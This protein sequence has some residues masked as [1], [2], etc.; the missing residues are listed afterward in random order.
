M[1]S[2]RAAGDA[3]AVRGVAE[4][5]LQGVVHHVARAGRPLGDV[6]FVQK[7]QG[8]AVHLK[9]VEVESGQIEFA[10]T[11][12]QE[13][14]DIL[15]GPRPRIWTESAGQLL[16]DVEEGRGGWLSGRGGGETGKRIAPQQIRTER[17]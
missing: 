3:A 14:D 12:S 7:A 17:K 1:R 10:F 9:F 5:Q 4:Q 13:G 16:F 6:R 2:Q 11:P 8:F 15:T